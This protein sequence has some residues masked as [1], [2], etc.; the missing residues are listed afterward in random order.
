M[1]RLTVVIA[2]Y[3]RADSLLRTL[4]TLLAQTLDHALWEVVVVDNNSKD[5]TQA[6]LA[7]FIAENGDKMNVRTFIETQQGISPARNRGYSEGRGEFFVFL[8]DD[9]EIDPALLAAFVEFFDSHPDAAEAGGEIIPLYDY[10][11]PRWLSPYT[12]TMLTGRFRKGRRI[13]LFRQGKYPFGGNLGVRRSVVER[14]GLFS[15]KLGRTGD[16]LMGGEEK[17]FADRLQSAGEKIYY[18]PAAKIYH[19]IPQDKM[20][21][22][23]LRKLSRMVGSSE[24][25]RTLGASRVAFVKS[26]VREAVKWAATCVLALWYTVTLRPSKAGYLFI[27]RWNVTCGLLCPGKK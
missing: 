8:D 11:P 13:K 3:N 26:L 22:A 15:P 10:D 6:K 24:R 17:D 20:T 21:R 27:M 12:E 2:T 23:Y 7:G 16:S 25:V 1:L 19:V 14:Y 4:R 9:E 18:L 5:D